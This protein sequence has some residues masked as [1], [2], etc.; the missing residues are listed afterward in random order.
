M[1]GQLPPL[2][3]WYDTVPLQAQLDLVTWQLHNDVGLPHK[4]LNMLWLLMATQMNMG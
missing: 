3:F 4:L 2:C 1:S